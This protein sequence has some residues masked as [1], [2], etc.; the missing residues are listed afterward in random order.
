VSDGVWLPKQFS[1]TAAARILLLKGFNREL[2]FTFSDYKKFQVDSHV[3][4]FSAKP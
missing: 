4:A 1:V 2:D 3:V